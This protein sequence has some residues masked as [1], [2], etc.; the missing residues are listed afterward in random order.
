VRK[1]KKRKEK[2]RKEKK[3]EEKNRVDG[4][5][6]RKEGMIKRHSVDSTQYQH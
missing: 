4:E 5:E 6:K 2:K 1:E 3:R